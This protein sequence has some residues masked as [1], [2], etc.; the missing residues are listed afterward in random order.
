MRVPNTG[1][2][3][4]RGQEDVKV[5]AK[6]QSD[7]V[8]DHRVGIHQPYKETLE[9]KEAADPMKYRHDRLVK[10]SIEVNVHG[11]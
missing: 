9:I 4:R 3:T 10:R 7:R 5:E 11:K 6:F 2:I 8:Q 1:R